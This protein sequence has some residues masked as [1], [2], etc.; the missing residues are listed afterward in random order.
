MSDKQDMKSAIQDVIAAMIDRVMEQVL[1]TDPFI[2][3]EHR[4]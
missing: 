3:E 1:E 4:A 2:K